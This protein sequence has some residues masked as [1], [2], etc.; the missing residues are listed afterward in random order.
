MPPTNETSPLR[1]KLG[2]ELRRLREA[3]PMSAEEAADSLELSPSTISRSETG[4]VNVH[5]REVEAMLQLYGVTDKHKV[6][7]L[8]ALARHAR[9]RGWWHK[10]RRLLSDDVLSFIRVEDGA[11]SIRTFQTMLVPGL[12][13]TPD[14][15]R[16]M[17]AVFPHEEPPEVVE[18]HLEVR[19]LRQQLL[20]EPDPVP[21]HVIFDISALQREV[22][23]PKV[24]RHQLE[25]LLELAGSDDVDVTLQVL[26]ERGAHV[27]FGGPFT[28]VGFPEPMHELA[29]VHMENQRNFF[30]AENEEDIRHYEVVFQRVQK[31]ALPVPDSLALVKEIAEAL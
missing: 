25:H 4:K 21:I 10:Y 20:V 14:Y 1:R 18:Q 17:A 31:S 16:A 27:G 11:N 30:L 6:D 3:M 22:G 2:M 19:R 5:P 23:G 9:E 29:I 13:Q 15:S 8:M 28:L 26:A 7:A 12:L 24:M